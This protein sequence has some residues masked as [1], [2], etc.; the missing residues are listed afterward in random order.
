MNNKRNRSNAGFYGA[1]AL[2]GQ[3]GLYIA[4]PMLIGA[5]AGQYIDHHISHIA[6]LA[7]I[8]GLLLGLAAGVFLVVRAILRLPQ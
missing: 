5:F 7:T 8:F 2:V 1:L 6:P 3:V 4:I